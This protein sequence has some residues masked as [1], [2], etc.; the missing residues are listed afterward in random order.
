MQLDHVVILVPDLLAASA[1]YRELGFNVVAGGA[2]GDGLT[3]NALIPF[4]DGTYLELIA[5]NDPGTPQLH[6]WWR[7]AALGGGLIDYALLSPDLAAAAADLNAAGLAVDGPHRGGR[8][9]PDG[10]ALAWEGAFTA[11]G[12]ALPFLI[13][14]LTPRELRVPSGDVT[15]HPNGVRGI[16][17][18]T[19]AVSDLNAT[20]AEYAA[21]LGG[22]VPA[23]REDKD[24]QAAT[25][26][27]R[28]DDAQVLLAQ[29]AARDAPL[30]TQ[31]AQRGPGIYA[32][33][34]VVDEAGATLGWL[35]WQRAHGARLQLVER[36][37]LA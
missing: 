25:A 27:L 34:L 8:A 19:V 22:G 24:M 7:Y 15:A 16:G 36:D 10:T 3:E 30:A 5:F 2:H 9:R 33:W 13:E 37:E 6:R 28:L 12:S 11:E 18:I 14:D 23:L 32:L 35:N 26:A 1:D 21:L 4:A 20:A 29:P 17:R 31:L